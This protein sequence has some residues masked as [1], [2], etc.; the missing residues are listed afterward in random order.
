MKEVCTSRKCARKMHSPKD[1]AALRALLPRRQDG[2]T[3]SGAP[4][5]Q[6]RW[7]VASDAVHGS[8]WPSGTH[9]R[10]Y[11]CTTSGLVTRRPQSVP[12]WFALAEA[13]APRPHRVPAPG[14]PAAPPSP[15]PRGFPS[16]RHRCPLTEKCFFLCISL[17][18]FPIK[19]RTSGFPRESG[20]SGNTR[21]RVQQGGQRQ[22]PRG[23]WTLRRRGIP[24]TQPLACPT[25]TLTW[26]CKPR[27]SPAPAWTPGFLS[28]RPHP[29]ISVHPAGPTA[30]RCSEF[31]QW[32]TRDGG[33]Y[34]VTPPESPVHIPPPAARPL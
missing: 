27:T 9:C 22:G 1:K 29:L 4:S 25:P 18:S 19:T 24:I 13:A 2:A 11:P 30:G 17:G 31:A 5:T 3:P 34:T 7:H 16:L 15:H 6:R 21:A 10:E 8:L 28:S 23:R 14:G 12:S 33:G 20:S 26:S 32:G